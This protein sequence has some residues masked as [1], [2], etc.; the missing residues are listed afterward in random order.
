ML[1]AIFDF[2]PDLAVPDESNFVALLGNMRDRYEQP[3]GFAVSAFLDDLFQQRSFRRWQMSRDFLLDVFDAEQPHGYPDAIR[4]IYALYAR[5]QGKVRYADKTPR[6]LMNIPLLA[7]LFPEA[8]VIHIIRD[9]RDV[10]LSV[11]DVDF[12]P[13]DIGAAALSWKEFVSEGRT[14]GQRLGERYLEIHYEDILESPEKS[15]RSLCEYIDLPFD[16]VMLRYFER[17]HEITAPAAWSRRHVL[18]PPTKGLRN[19]RTQMAPKDVVAFEAL[20]GDLLEELD[21]ERTLGKAPARVLLQARTTML[22]KRVRGLGRKARKSVTNRGAS[23]GAHRTA[24]L[25]SHPGSDRKEIFSF[26]LAH[27][28]GEQAE[29]KSFRE[30]ILGTR[31]LPLEHLP[32]WIEEQG[33][34]ERT[35]EPAQALEYLGGSGWPLRRRAAQG[36]VLERLGLLSAKLA[37]IYGWEQA[38]ASTFVLTGLPPLISYVRTTM[39]GGV[40][41]SSTTRIV[42]EVNPGV[43]PRQLAGHYKRARARVISKSPDKVTDKR[44]QLAVFVAGHTDGDWPDVM[45]LWNEKFPKWRYKDAETFQRE[46]VSSRRALLD[47]Y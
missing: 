43:T 3:H 18:L 39:V 44:A 24:L 2:H 16:S 28:A 36:G 14:A 11:L 27:E 19:W 10:A 34:R 8:R 46:A 31:L 21:Y 33:E 12:G 45:R 32:T 6:N 4:A 35:G 22:G 47:P 5:R 26:L 7:Q 9:G 13:K 42:L 20:A 23:K 40:P 29:V 41:L 30:D 17:S 15:V 1:R 37:E 25:T 38:Q